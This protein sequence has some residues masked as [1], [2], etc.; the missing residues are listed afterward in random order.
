MLGLLTL[1]HEFNTNVPAGLNP[2][3][4]FQRQ[5]ATGGRVPDPMG[6]LVAEFLVASLSACE[7]GLLFTRLA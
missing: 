3:V 5:R 2:Y 6:F 4:R 7:V 1:N